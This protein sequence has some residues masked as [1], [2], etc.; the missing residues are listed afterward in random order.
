M[1]C[2]LFTLLNY[3]IF[4]LLFIV[5]RQCCQHG[6]SKKGA[7]FPVSRVKGGGKLTCLQKREGRRVHEKQLFQ[8]PDPVVFIHDA[9][10][11][12]NVLF[13]EP[14][15]SGSRRRKENGRKI[16]DMQCNRG[17]DQNNLP[18]MPK[19]TI[20]LRPLRWQEKIHPLHL[21]SVNDLY[22]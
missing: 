5:L 3:N 21:W 19:K 1:M 13:A 8:L 12:F 22:P 4:S 7:S 17:K 14:C 15:V 9:L 10:F 11:S 6:Y 18:A 20:R 16:E 2:G